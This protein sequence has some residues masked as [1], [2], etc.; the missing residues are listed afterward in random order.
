M[1]QKEYTALKNEHKELPEFSTLDQEFYISQ[2]DAKTHPLLEIKKKIAE[3]MESSLNFLTGLLNPEGLNIFECKS[4]TRKDQQELIDT[5]RHLM[6][7]YR[8][9]LETDIISTEK[10]HAN[11][12]TQTTKVWLDNKQKLLDIIQK[13]RCN[14]QKTIEPNEVL[15]YLG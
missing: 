11:A 6:E 13:T 15:D 12:I 4:L 1:E 14:W 5:Y 8:L 9:I 2:I 10:A 7:H 3:K